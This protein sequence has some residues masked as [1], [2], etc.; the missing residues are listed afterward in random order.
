MSD[1]E[2]GD[3]RASLGRLTVLKVVKVD[4]S[5]RLELS[6]N[7]ETGMCCSRE[8]HR[9]GPRTVTNLTVVAQFVREKED[10]SAQQ[11]SPLSPGRLGRLS[12][13][14]RDPNN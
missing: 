11:D 5:V 8:Q 9:C 4:Y 7:S 3:G 1:S 2:A 10:H 13:A 14:S 12:G 6:A